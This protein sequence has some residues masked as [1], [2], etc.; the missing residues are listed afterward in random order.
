MSI[1]SGG[2]YVVRDGEPVLVER[3]QEPGAEPDQPSVQPAPAELTEQPAP[4]ELSDE[5]EDADDADA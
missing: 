5:Q 1:S 4:P 2:R 3:T